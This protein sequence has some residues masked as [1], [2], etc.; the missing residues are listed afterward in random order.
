[1]AVREQGQSGGRS[2]PVQ[3]GSSRRGG[4]TGRHHVTRKSEGDFQCQPEVG[5]LGEPPMGVEPP[6]GVGFRE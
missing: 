6:G 5:W 1:M 4:W 2:G 3:A